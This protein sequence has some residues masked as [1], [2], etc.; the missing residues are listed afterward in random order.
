MLTVAVAGL[1][2]SVTP[3]SGGAPAGRFDYFVRDDFFAGL[4]G[5]RARLDQ[6][7]KVCEEAL[8]ADPRHAEA[9][10]WHGAGLI[11]RG[12]QAAQ[13]GD[14]QKAG[15]LTARGLEEMDAGAR[16]APTKIGVLVVRAAILSRLARVPFFA[17][18]EREWL[19]IAV[20]HYGTALTLQAPQFAQM[21]THSRGELLGGLAENFDRLGQTERARHYLTRIVTELP[22]TTYAARARAWLATDSPSPRATLSCVGCHVR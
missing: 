5:D 2:L 8:V 17:D 20:A 21:S 7:M 1:L 15:P 4:A 22:D 14:V 13:A 19:E 16:L 12:G 9:M 18:R 3:S 11:V 6:A 10:V